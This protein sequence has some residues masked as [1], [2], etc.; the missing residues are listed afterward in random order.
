MKKATY[1]GKPKHVFNRPAF[2]ARANDM[3]VK[4][5]R[6]QAKRKK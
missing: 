1:T 6:N 5:I 4:S 3:I 2:E